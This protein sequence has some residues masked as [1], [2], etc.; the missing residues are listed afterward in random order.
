MQQISQLASAEAAYKGHVVFMICKSETDFTL[1]DVTQ[2]HLRH[3]FDPCA[4]SE[5]KKYCMTWT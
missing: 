4:D 2:S 1:F 3:I 5:R